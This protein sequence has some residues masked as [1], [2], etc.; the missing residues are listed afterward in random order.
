M[1]LIAN[2][3]ELHKILTS[4]YRYSELT[5]NILNIP[6]CKP[7]QL[8]RKKYSRIFELVVAIELNLQLWD[9]VP[10]YKFVNCGENLKTF[11]NRSRKPRDYGIDCVNES[12]T[13]AVQV[14]WYKPNSAVKWSDISTFFALATILHAEEKLIV[15]SEG[16][17]LVKLALDLPIRHI[18]ISDSQIN[19]ICASL[20]SSPKPSNQIPLLDDDF[21]ELPD[22]DEPDG[23]FFCGIFPVMMFVIVF[24]I[25]VFGIMSY[26]YASK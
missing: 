23:N 12:L 8:D 2:Q 11:I 24:I 21:L 7:S 6:S 14:K 9:N 19:I 1:S 16:V 5:E 18:I 26:L 15:T 25:L 4:I 20:M 3:I 17:K 13:T 22:D 10:S